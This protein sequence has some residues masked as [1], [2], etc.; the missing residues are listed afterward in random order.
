MDGGAPGPEGGQRLRGIS[1][2]PASPAA[3]HRTVSTDT[4]HLPGR[5]RLPGWAHRKP[6]GNRRP[7]A[8]PLVLGNAR[9]LKNRRKVQLHTFL[10]RLPGKRGRA[11]Q[12]HKW[13]GRSPGDTRLVQSTPRPSWDGSEV[14]GGP[15]AGVPGSVSVSGFSSF[16]FSTAPSQRGSCRSV[17]PASFSPSAFVSTCS[18]P[19]PPQHGSHRPPRW[20]ARRPCAP[21]HR[22]ESTL[23]ADALQTSTCT[24]LPVSHMKPPAP[25]QILGVTLFSSPPSHPV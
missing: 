6:V 5:L 19:W 11:W 20:P 12:S 25:G 4:S 10:T 9:G 24:G 14:Q 18:G 8:I 3:P 15:I 23:R 2:T 1:M 22:P 21:G 7:T 17:S 16:S 13:A